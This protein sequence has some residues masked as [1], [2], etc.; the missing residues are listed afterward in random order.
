MSTY[1][2]PDILAGLD[3]ARRAEKKR[4]SRLRVEFDGD[5][6]PVVRMGHDGFALDIG[7]LLKVCQFITI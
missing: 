3:T 2:P 5:M 6:Y 7:V 1:L 4:K